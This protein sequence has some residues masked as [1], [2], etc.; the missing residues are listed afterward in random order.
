MNGWDP[1]VHGDIKEENILLTTPDAKEHQLY[2]AIKLADFGLGY[3]TGGGEI[4][5]Q[6]FKSAKSYGTN[7][8]IAPEVEDDTPE[9]EG[10][11]RAPHE[12]HGSHSDVYS[13]GPCFDLA[14]ELLQKHVPTATS[15]REILHNAKFTK[16][17]AQ[18]AESVYSS[19]FRNLVQSFM[20]RDARNRPKAYNIYRQAKARM[21]EYRNLAYREEFEAVQNGALRGCFHS[22]VLYT[23]V[24]QRRYEEDPAFRQEYRDANL[25]PLWN[26]LGR[27][28][29][30]K[31]KPHLRSGKMQR[32]F[33]ALN[34]ISKV[35]GGR[36]PDRKSQKR[37]G[38]RLSEEGR[39]SQTG[40]KARK[41]GAKGK[42]LLKNLL[43]KMGF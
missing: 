25:A 5:V 20:E 10:R 2:P 33:D 38:R 12:L 29:R 42:G 34:R 26:A 13:L 19:D 23:R 37:S 22:S 17:M 4:E 3:T 41:R 35:R 21:E 24:A 40:P 15:F 1:I 27:Q 8:Y 43:S 18:R 30:P 7:G 31:R 14:F 16:D 11:R 28:P 6:R 36:I 9:R 39:M 32:D